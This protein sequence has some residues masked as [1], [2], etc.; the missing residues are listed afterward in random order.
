[1]PERE[2]ERKRVVICARGVADLREGGIESSCDIFW[3]MGGGMR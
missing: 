1:M 2:E 3:V